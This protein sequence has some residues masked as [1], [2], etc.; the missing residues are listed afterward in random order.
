MFH[1]WFTAG[2]RVYECHFLASGDD[3]P[4]G[5]SV[6]G[7]CCD[8]SSLHRCLFPSSHCQVRQPSRCSLAGK[9]P[10]TLLRRNDFLSP[11]ITSLFVPGS[12]RSSFRNLFL[13]RP[14]VPAGLR[15]QTL[16]SP[17]F[18]F[19]FQFFRTSTLFLFSFLVPLVSPSHS[20]L[21]NSG[22]PHCFSVYSS[23]SSM[24]LRLLLFGLL[25]FFH[26]YLRLYACVKLNY[27]L[28]SLSL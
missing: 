1:V 10:S 15:Y 20:V 6:D 28:S 9:F 12:K 7:D 3:E 11:S 25:I 16:C 13:H 21:S 4:P 5:V 8:P 19:V 2:V 17:F 22:F 14:L 24:F 23:F 26:F 18:V 27:L